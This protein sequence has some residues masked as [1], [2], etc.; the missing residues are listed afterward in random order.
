MV[1]KYLKIYGIENLQNIFIHGFIYNE[2]LKE[3][4]NEDPH[5]NEDRYIIELNFKKAKDTKKE[6]HN[7]GDI[8]KIYF[9]NEKSLK[10]FKAT[11][12]ANLPIYD[13][14]LEVNEFFFKKT[15][16]LD[17]FKYKNNLLKKFENNYYD[18][19]KIDIK[20]GLLSSV[21]YFFT[22]DKKS[23]VNINGIFSILDIKN[24]EKDFEEISN[25]NVNI[26][27]ENKIIKDNINDYKR[28]HCFNEIGLIFI[29]LY[30]FLNGKIF[31]KRLF[32]STE[33]NYLSLFSKI[34]IEVNKRQ[35]TKDENYEY[36]INNI[37]EKLD[38]DFY[39]KRYIHY[40]K[41]KKIVDDNSLFEYLLIILLKGNFNLI[42]NN[43]ILFQIKNELLEHVKLVCY[44]LKGLFE[45]YK[46]LENEIKFV[47]YKGK[48][49]DLILNKSSKKLEIRKDSIK[50][51]NLIFNN[52]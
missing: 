33:E 27:T 5:I 7:V 3:N 24:L 44:I 52:Y 26:F 14:I 22:L 45:G 23:I 35:K 46:N 31:K 16:N 20:L 10:N 32:D 30:N 17:L 6:Y 34:L 42:L 51:G 37:L 41:N 15:N 29:V 38:L 39:E 4:N 43:P 48:V 2:F 11:T 13:K 1:K 25:F 49:F 8:N 28:T 50:Y 36:Y 9:V 18:K 19:I 40:I 47:A 12:Y 21:Y